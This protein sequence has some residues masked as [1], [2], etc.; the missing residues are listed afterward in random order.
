L[1]DRVRRRDFV[2]VIASL[3]VALNR[4]ARAQQGERVRRIGVLMA[5]RE[6]DPE[7]GKYLGAFRQGLEKFGWV[8]GRNLRIETRWGALDDAEIRQR[9]AK[10]LLATNPDIIL[11]QNTPPTA[12]MLQETRTVPVVFVIVTDPVGSGFVKS[13]ARPGGNATGF[14]IMEPTTGGKWLELL[15]EVAPQTKRVVFLFN[16]RTAPYANYYL[17]PFKAASVSLGVEPVAAIVDSQSDLENVFAAQARIPDTG[18]IAMPDGFLNVHRA[19]V[20]SLAARYRLPTVYPWRFF[21]ELGG[22]MSYG[23]DQGEFFASAATYIDRILKGEKP[24]DLPVQAPTKY[25]LVI[26]RRAAKDLG[27]TLPTSLLGRADDLID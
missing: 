26:N 23:F 13:L 6:A 1:G 20:V 19:E 10:E 11:T 3:S 2:K 24:A 17:D 15:K 4:A 9:S 18:L 22:L 21:T 8:E 25:E 12:S 16:P 7:F 5:H 14:T 27:L